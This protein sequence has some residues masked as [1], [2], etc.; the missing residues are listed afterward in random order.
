VVEL[1]F[2][3]VYDGELEAKARAIYTRDYEIF[4]FEDYAA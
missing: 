2:S 1:A 3:N 4:G